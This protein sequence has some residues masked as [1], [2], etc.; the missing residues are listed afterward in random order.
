MSLWPKNQIFEEVDSECR[1]LVNALNLIPGASTLESCCGHGKEPF[2]IWI[3]VFTDKALDYLDWVEVQLWNYGTDWN[4]EIL[5]EEDR[6]DFPGSTCLLES[7][8]KGVE[9][10]EEAGHRAK[11]IAE[12]LSEHFTAEE[13]ADAKEP[14]DA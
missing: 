3:D 2:R 11:F 12:H 10:Y 14:S 4:L 5:E 7:G 8:S 9:A 1:E 13:L 6:G